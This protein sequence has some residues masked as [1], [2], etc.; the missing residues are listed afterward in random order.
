VELVRNRS[1]VVFGV[2]PNG[3]D[4][5]SGVGVRVIWRHLETGRVVKYVTFT[6]IPYNAVGDTVTD[7]L[8]GQAARKLRATGPFDARPPLSAEYDE[9]S[10][11]DAQWYNSTIS[12]I[13]LA[14]VDV[15]YMDGTSKSYT[16][17]LGDALSAE[18]QNE[19]V[20]R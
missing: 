17:N 9:E 6:V 11:W 7:R 5:A 19:C 2:F 12:C 15:E 13:H 4:S 10:S 3:P 8:S 16:G 20:A 14:R 1:L 18:F